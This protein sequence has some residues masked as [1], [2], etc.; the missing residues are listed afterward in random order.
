MKYSGIIIGKRDV[1]EVDRLYAVYTL[2]QGRLSIL[3]KGVRKAT[4]KLAGNLE[5]LS[6]AEIYVSKGRGQGNITGAIALDSFL[7]LKADFAALNRAFYAVSYF[8][9]FITQEEKD[10][11]SFHFLLEYL[12]VMDALAMEGKEES[13]YD[14]VT[15]GFLFKF[16]E[17]VGYG[18]DANYCSVCEEKIKEGGNFFSAKRGGIV[19][20]NCVRGEGQMVKID[21]HSVKLIRIFYKNRISSL[22]KLEVGKRDVS[23]LRLV[24]QEFVNWIK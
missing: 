7:F 4:A 3:G 21:D 2:E 1:R 23:N 12:K 22:S 8:N 20:A 9:K 14:A 19:C 15:F 17:N 11:K 16:L 10:E 18:I 5:T 13:K 24:F 6:H